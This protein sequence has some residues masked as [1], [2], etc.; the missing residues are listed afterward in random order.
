MKKMKSNKYLEKVTGPVI[1]IPTP[2][3]KSQDVD[4]A[5]L[6][7]YIQFLVD[8]GIKNVMTTVGTSRFNLLSEEE[9]KRVNETI[10]ESVDGKA[11]TIVANPLTGGTKHAI[12]FAKHS[13]EIGADLFMAYFPERHYGEENTFKF[14]EQVCNNISIGV[15]IHEMPKRSGLGGGPVHY[16]LPLLDKLFEIDNLVGL[17]EE[18]L[19]ADYS[20]QIVE[21][22]S[23]IAVIIGAGGG[24]SRYLYRDFDLGAK[25]FLGAVGNFIPELELEFFDAITSGNKERATQI[26]EELEQPFFEKAVPMG[27]HPGLKAALALKGLM[28][29]YEREPMKFMSGA[30]VEELKSIMKSYNWL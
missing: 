22:F 21:R 17:K 10:V 1:P 12:D 6:K 3:T 25:T 28:P 19:D 16:S 11:V 18:A 9:V 30:E 23:K 24:M 7:S 8:R 14:F 20:N 4:Y 27:W 13:E 29:I 15:L 5:A 26:V 2:F